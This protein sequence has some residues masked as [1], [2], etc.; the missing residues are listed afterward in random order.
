MSAG[1]FIAEAN[2]DGTIN[3]G[4]INQLLIGPT[5][6][7]YPDRF[8]NEVRTS[9]D[10]Y[11]IVQSPLKDTRPRS[12]V[13]TRY[14]SSV[15]KY[16]T[17]YNQLLNYQYKMR[18]SSTPVKSPWVWVK[19]TETGN[20]TYKQWNGTKW[21]EVETWVRVKVIQVT[22]NIARQGGYAVYDETRMTFSI[23]DATWNN[24]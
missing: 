9:K 12:W 2:L 14:R 24:F 16:D 23:D 7:E 6:V 5:Y 1:F 19:D 15:P 4:T 17:V 21:I 20:L 3:S 10:G 22:Q 18:Q 13:W 11:S 8:V